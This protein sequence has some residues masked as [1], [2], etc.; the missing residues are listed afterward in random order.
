V[1][2]RKPYHGIN[3]IIAHDGFTLCDLVSY[4]SKVTVANNTGVSIYYVKCVLH[5][6]MPFL[7]NEII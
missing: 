6:N 2:N 7:L 4:N 1:N 5:A 3:F